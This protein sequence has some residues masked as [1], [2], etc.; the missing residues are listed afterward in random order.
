LAVAFATKLRMAAAALG[1]SSRKEFCARFRAANAATQCD[2]DRLSKWVQG[3]SLPRAPSVYADF[4]AVIGTAKSG[5][6]VAD[7]SPEEFAAEL[8]ARTGVDAAT[9][10]LPDSLSRPG[11]SHAAG[12]LG[13]AATLTGAFAGYSPVWS[14]QYHGR[15]LRGALRL[16][17]SRSGALIATYAE[18][19]F[20]RDMHLT[21]EVSISGR[22]MHFLLREPAGDMPVFISA[23]L[24]GP[25][26]SVLCG[27]M[28]GVAFLSNEPLPSASRIV[29]IRVRDTSRLDGTNRF[30]DPVPGAIA[31]DLAD[32]GIDIP[33]ARRLDSFTR[34]FVGTRPNQVT[35]QDQATFASMLDHQ[36][37]GSAGDNVSG[38]R[39]VGPQN[40]RTAL[41]RTDQKTVVPL[42]RES[43]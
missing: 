35:T 40:S 7:C 36:H 31:A 14:P 22:A 23:Q 10:A 11:K 42:K 25:P 12:L 1:C 24:P 5:R 38:S 28:S 19:F 26:A 27:V 37:L 43:R 21:A 39:V 15:V 6:W 32:L 2:P 9:V 29:F 13:G 41:G 33:E 4:A 16:A 17:S 30:F 8:I 3:R 20:G 18:S 34:E